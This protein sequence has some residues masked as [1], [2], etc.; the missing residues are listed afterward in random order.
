MAS[1]HCGGPRENGQKA[2]RPYLSHGFSNPLPRESPASRAYSHPKSEAEP[3]SHFLLSWVLYQ[4]SPII[5]NNVRT[6]FCLFKKGFH[7]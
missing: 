2:G 4:G 7:L 6:S 1:R 3:P 5:P